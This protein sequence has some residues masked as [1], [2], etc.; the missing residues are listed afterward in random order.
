MLIVFSLPFLGTKILDR[1]LAVIRDLKTGGGS[2]NTR[3]QNWQVVWQTIKNRESWHQHLLGTGPSTIAYTYLKNRP[4]FLNQNPIEKNWNTTV[5]RNQFLDILTNTGILGLFF[6]L[7]ILA[8]LFSQIAKNL[9]TL[10]KNPAFWLAI[11][12]FSIIF[13]SSLFYYQTITTSVY[14][15]FSLGL[16]TS[17]LGKQK[18]KLKKPFFILLVGVSITTASLI[19]LGKV[20]IADLAFSKE[21]FEKAVKI[22]PYNNVYKRQLISSLVKQAENNKDFEKAKQA[23]SQAEK[24]VSIN[25]VSAGNQ[26]ALQLANYKTGVLFDKSFHQKALAAGE[27]RLVFDP[28]HAGPYDTQGL[29]YL[30]VGELKK[31]LFYFKK[32][33]EVDPQNLESYLHAGEALKQ[34]G[35]IEK[36]IIYYQIALEK[37]PNWPFAQKEL[38]KVKSL[39]D[40]DLKDIR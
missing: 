20:I 14:F 2:I 15:W 28:S 27:K 37:N 24:A 34:M 26:Y 23:I 39:L 10:A 32:A 3:L 9:K 38:E 8:I 7:A 6:F 13:F 21:N 25:P 11:S 18:L 33:L 5:V 36:A 22:N 40:K 17:I 1:N 30:D 16:L 31:A 19:T 12:S 35:K 29:I 4:T